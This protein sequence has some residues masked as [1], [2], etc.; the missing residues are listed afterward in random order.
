MEYLKYLNGLEIMAGLNFTAA[1]EDLSAQDMLS[2]EQ[3]IRL[4]VAFQ[5]EMSHAAEVK[6]MLKALGY[7]DREEL[8]VIRVWLANVLDSVLAGFVPE[9]RAYIRILLNHVIEEKLAR[10][11]NTETLGAMMVVA[12]LVPEV[13]EPAWDFYE[14]VKRDEPQHVELDAEIIALYQSRY[15]DFTAATALQAMRSRGTPFYR[16][17]RAKRVFIQAA[18]NS[19][20]L[21]YAAS[22][23]N[24]VSPRPA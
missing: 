17:I 7:T 10:I 12:D 15:P 3:F 9:Q 18:S 21:E 22:T 20:N 1:R 11:G 6:R 16:A 4:N 8:M 14:A 24:A 19:L 23:M 13:R 5:Q 2:Y